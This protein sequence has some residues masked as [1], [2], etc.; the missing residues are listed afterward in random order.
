MLCQRNYKATSYPRPLVFLIVNRI[1][2]AFDEQV[3]EKRFRL[4]SSLDQ[5]SYILIQT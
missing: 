1:H 3:F 5:Y 4:D 2:A